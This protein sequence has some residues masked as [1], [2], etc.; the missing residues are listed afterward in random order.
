MSGR[1]WG[2]V[3][4][5]VFLLAVLTLLCKPQG[6]GGQLVASLGSVLQTLVTYAAGTPS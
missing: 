3:A 1:D 6:Q 5:A 2:D 4:A